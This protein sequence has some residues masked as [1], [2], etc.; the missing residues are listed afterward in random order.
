MAV[1][2]V[3]H[4]LWQKMC[5]LWL[6]NIRARTT[7]Q[8]TTKEDGDTNDIEETVVQGAMLGT[9]SND[10]NDDEKACRP[11]VPN[12]PSVSPPKAPPIDL[13]IV[14]FVPQKKS[15]M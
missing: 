10:D 12:T 9:Y 4:Q 1:R 14:C 7:Q 15:C 3:R 5:C 2:Q 8:S 6:R 13:P 11:T